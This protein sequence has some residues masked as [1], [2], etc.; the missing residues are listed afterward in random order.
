[1]I[2]PLLDLVPQM[3]TKIKQRCFGVL[4]DISQEKV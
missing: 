3:R 2:A 4:S 1:M